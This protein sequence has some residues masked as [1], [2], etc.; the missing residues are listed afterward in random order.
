MAPHMFFRLWKSEAGTSIIELGLLLPILLML[1]LGSI[2]L[3]RGFA[4]RLDLEQA[5]QAT[6]DLALARLPRDRND[7]AYLV[8]EAN[9]AAGGGATPNIQLILTCDGAPQGRFE[10]D[11][12]RAAQIRARF[13]Q[14]SITKPYTPMFE[15]G[16]LVGRQVIASTVTLTGDS[17]VRIQ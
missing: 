6:T 4:A 13:V 17:K 5:A 1:S 3:A 8:A 10:N 2:D 12:P 15:W 7:T 9:R 16:A 14:V 11:C